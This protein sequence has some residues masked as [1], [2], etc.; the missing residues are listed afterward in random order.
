MPLYLSSGQSG[1]R[2]EASSPLTTS[3]TEVGLHDSS[4]GS[5]PVQQASAASHA[6]ALTLAL[7]MLAYDAAFMH[8][9][10]SS[11]GSNGTARA[12]DEGRLP[13][14]HD[15]LG[16]LVAALSSSNVERFTSAATETYKST[17]WPA[18]DFTTFRRIL[19]TAPATDDNTVPGPQRSPAA[20]IDSGGL[21]R[22]RHTAGLSAA[23]RVL[24]ER[25]ALSSPNSPNVSDSPF[26]DPDKDDEWDVL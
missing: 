8:R 19:E 10:L 2:K 26:G 22:K 18:L 1:S 3:K 5:T 11:D 24:P 20:Q 6:Q 25:P 12:S 17:E 21:A 9:A 15:V 23:S 16:T 14:Y 13:E 7:H 4:L